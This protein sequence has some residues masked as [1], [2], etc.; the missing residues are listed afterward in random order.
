MIDSTA[1]LSRPLMHNY[2]ENI[3]LMPILSCD[4][5]MLPQFVPDKRLIRYFYSDDRDLIMPIDW[6][7]A[8]LHILLMLRIV[9][10]KPFS[11]FYFNPAR[12]WAAV[13]DTYTYSREF[14]EYLL[15]DLTKEEQTEGALL[16]I[17][18][19]AEMGEESK[20]FEL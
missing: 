9:W 7:L 8:Y 6:Y 14:L 5:N 17:K 16:V 15:E 19:L 1:Y 3:C 12:K 10:Y 4:F 20:R 13:L 11:G 2:D 18:R